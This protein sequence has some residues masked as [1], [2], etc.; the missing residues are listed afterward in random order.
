MKPSGKSMSMLATALLA[1]A[2]TGC[3]L[4]DEK[5]ARGSVVEN[6]IAGTIRTG[7]GSAAAG[8]S[9]RIFAADSGSLAGNGPVGETRT[10][11]QG[12]YRISGL[13]AGAYTLLGQSDGLYAFHD[14]IVVARPPGDPG[15]RTVRLA[16]DTLK[17][18]GAIA[19]QVVLRPGDDRASIRGEVLGTAF[20]AGALGNGD[21][22]MPG[23]PAGRLRI[24][25]T[26]TLPGYKPL[27]VAVVVSPGE[28]TQAGVLVLPY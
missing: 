2:L 21:L 6:E 8:A 1:A 7:D 16:D 20:N 10:D 12:A 13:A 18:T 3:L 4:G 24:R 9:V 23:M 11:A 17:A 22:S 25:F 14:S 5:T 15:K 27:Q 28:T 19:V 26:S